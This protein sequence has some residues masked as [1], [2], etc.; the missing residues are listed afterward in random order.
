MEK[1]KF[2]YVTFIR[3]TPEKLWSALTDPKF[4]RQYFFNSYQESAWKTGAP[5][6]M[7]FPDGHAAASGEV[8]MIDPPRKLVLAWK[9]EKPELKDEAV[10]LL[11]YQ[12][13]QQDDMV[14]LTVLHESGDG[15]DKLIQAVSSGWPMILA[16]LKSLLET[17]ES[18]PS[19]RNAPA[20]GQ[21]GANR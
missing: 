16:S 3:T 1:P 15:S 10:S 18:L 6:K 4:T 20:N 19:T 14:K 17:G 12:L 7:V 2:V 21:C 8:L 9:G 13:E 11:T 5:W